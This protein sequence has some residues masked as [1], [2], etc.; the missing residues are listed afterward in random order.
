[1]TSTETIDRVM[2]DEILGRV[3]RVLHVPVSEL[4]KPN[5]GKI[6]IAEARQVA[7]YL[8][9]HLNGQNLSRAGEVMDRDRTT[10]RY[11]VD[12]VTANKRLRDTAARIMVGYRNAVASSNPVSK[13]RV[14]A[15]RPG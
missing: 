6:G 2:R 8:L 10:I 5:R 15:P 9:F 13:E 1:M 14:D 7:M 4:L 11:A 12:K 3:A